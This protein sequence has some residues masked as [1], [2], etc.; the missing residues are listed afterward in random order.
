MLRSIAR[1]ALLV[2]VCW[3]LGCGTTSRSVRS[4]GGARGGVGKISY[5]SD[6]LAG[7]PTAS[8]VPYDPG[9]DTCAHRKIPF[10]TRVR[11][12]LTDTGAAA[13]CEVNDRGPFVRGRILDVSRAVAKKLGLLKRGVASGKVEVIRRPR[14]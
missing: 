12:T 8:G 5:Y 4:G 7:R 3:A 6:A 14:S 1:A 11:V 13:T 9:E 10:G 2:M